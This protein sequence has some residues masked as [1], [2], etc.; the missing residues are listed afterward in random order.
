MQIKSTSSE[1]TEH[2]AASFGARLRGGEIFVLKS[3]LGGGKTT[4]T[5]GLARGASSSDM[6]SS[7]T[8][9]ISKIYDAPNFKIHHF[10]FYRLGEPGM[11]G[12]ELEELIGDTSV[13]LVLEW[14]IVISELLPSEKVIV[15][16]EVAGEQ[17]REFTFSYPDSL[18]YLF[19][20]L[21]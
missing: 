5:R 14:P 2:L 13:V 16:I 15:D 6:V 17:Q 8:F 11:V 20:G 3:D 12:A 18:G 19:E 21:A 9:T 4:F 1:Q 7:P 10:D